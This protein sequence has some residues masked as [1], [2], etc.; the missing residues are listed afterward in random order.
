MR[1]TTRSTA[2]IATA[3]T[4]LFAGGVALS[5]ATAAP[6]TALSSAAAKRLSTDVDQ[7]V[8]VVLKDQVASV[9]AAP[10]TLPERKDRVEQ[11]QAPVISELDATSADAI[12]PYTAINAVAATVSSGEV[13]RLEANPAVAQVV[14]DRRIQRPASEA[15]TTGHH[16]GGGGTSGLPG[17]CRADGKPQLE[18]QAL[19]TIKASS[20]DPSA[21]TARSLGFT[22]TGVKVGYIADGIDIN[23]P[24]FIRSNGDHVFV[25]YKDFSGEGT[26]VPTGGGEAFLDAG[27]VAAQGHTVYDISGFSPVA[28]K[29]PCKIRIEGV[30]PGVSLVGLSIFG[31]EDTGYNSSFLAAIDYAVTVSHVNVL[32]ES[33]GGQPYP[34]DDASLDLIKAANDAAVAAGIT[35]VTSSGDAGVTSTIGSP[36]TDPKVISTA[37]S[38]TY[39]LHTQVGYGGARF[40]GVKG[41]IDDNISSLSSGGYTQTGAT[42]NVT[43]PG[44]LNWAPC[45]TDVDHYYDC[46]DYSGNPSPIQA[47]GGTSE[48]APLTAGTAALI[49][50]AYAKSHGG[51]KP[52]PAIIGQ[53]LESTADDISAPAE[54]Q[55][56]GLV[57][58][59]KAVLA[60]QAYGNPRAVSRAKPGTILTSVG[61][62]NEVDAP[63]ATQ[64]LKETITNNGPS[65]QLVKL[66]TRALGTYSPVKKATVTLDGSNPK[67]TDWAGLP[68]NYQAVTFTVP[69][70]EDRL[71][72]DIAFQGRD[73]EDLASRVR[74]TLIDPT[75]KLA[76]YSVPQGVGNYG[77]AEVANPAAGR[78]TAYIWS[79]D[80]ANGGTTG[81]VLFGASVASFT[82]FGSVSPSLLILGPG[83]SAQA[84]VSVKTP[85]TPGDT[86]GALVIRSG[87]GLAGGTTNTVP[88]TLRSLAPTGPTTFSGVLT[89]GNGRQ[90]NTGQAN[91]YQLKLPAGQPE[92]N[93]SITLADD[94]GN[95]TYAWL[96]DPSGNA[97]AF[98]S[99]GVISNDDAGDI[100]YTNTLGTNLHV[101][102]P[103]AGLWT[104]IVLFAPA[105]SGNALSE[106]FT[107]SLNQDAVPSSADGLPNAAS[108]TLPA[109][110]PTTV[111][112]T[113]KNTG[114]APE[115][116]FVDGRLDGSTQYDLPGSSGSS[117][118]A[119]LTFNDNFPLFLVPT[120]TTRVDGSASTT[121]STPIRFDLQPYA[122]DPD[123]ASNVGSSVTASY[124]ASPVT[125]GLWGLA[126]TVFGAFGPLGVDREPVETKLVATTKPFDTAVS[127]DLGD[128]WQSALDPNASFGTTI[129]D[130]GET[131]TIP[132]TIT[133]DAAPGTVVSG[134]LFV[135]DASLVVFGSLA[136][137]AN[138]VAALPYTYTVK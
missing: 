75:G 29:G 126:P 63:N 94:P 74:L 85:K 1:A 124:A 46:F 4:G 123:V 112:V 65:T 91:Y 15:A 19:Q 10:S 40:P 14:P 26:A 13:D 5:T 36:A 80:T 53:I 32:N 43:A 96:V 118:T 24:E 103:A 67:T 51:K 23:N 47:S 55:G 12:H 84:T 54:Q 60:A 44:E 39:R 71:K 134:T 89:G 121:G 41:W 17:T 128:L 20:D 30:A 88:I 68:A 50:E 93:A 82:S 59:Y 125:Q 115:S 16:G 98:A 113:V 37:A 48:S 101:L 35:V 100:Q 76:D 106:P 22:G 137:N 119:P 117:T 78:W 58:A 70:G 108:A 132:V 120:E 52:T 77:N 92:L 104:V 83:Q 11:A 21:K 18:P 38:T 97:Q 102:K 129:V 7:K 90:V 61:Q 33:L 86:A 2:V 109:G 34:D 138:H 3:I 49:I 81:P 8:I 107:V 127:T 69:R 99:N 79:R 133:P 130:P 122:G 87:P 62:F 64:K 45:S 111:N 136:P 72:A 105:V 73:P 42:V 57:D 114:T 28:V 135:D 66:S 110:K 95:Q 56:A 9:P 31:N 6:Q 27:S 116:Y 131:A 25:D